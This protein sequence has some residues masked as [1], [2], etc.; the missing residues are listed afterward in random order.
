MNI[1]ERHIIACNLQQFLHG[2]QWPNK[3]QEPDYVAKLVE[4][5]PNG[6]V[7]ASTGILSGCKLS[8]GSAFIHQKPLA[9]F[10]SK[11]GY[12]DSELG[13][14]LIV[15][16]ENRFSGTFY[17]AMLLQAKCTSTPFSQHIPNDHQYVLY[18]EWPEFE[19]K[20]AGH[21]NGLT[22]SVLPKAITQG[23][24]YLLID[25]S[26]QVELLTATVNIPLASSKMFART[27]AALLS[28]DAGRTFEVNYHRDNWSQMILDL[29][30]IAATS[31]FTRR[32]G[33][34]VKVPRWNGDAA[35]DCILNV[36]G[37]NNTV[38]IVQV[39][40]TTDDGNSTGMGVVCVDISY[41]DK[42]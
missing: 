26:T 38:D 42:N 29:L 24:Q 32:N 18:S 27:I 30:S 41:P 11:T 25:V 35:I 4:E 2:I 33:G 7:N 39:Q 1:Y 10:T 31:K 20:R 37:Q 34:F 15:I 17:N 16:R 40:K 12:K 8:V 21:L 28:F 3:A 13:D 19:Y 5:L 22:R 9:H 36:A 23:A 14:L 6:I